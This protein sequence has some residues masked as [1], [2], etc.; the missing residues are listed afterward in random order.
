MTL[1]SPRDAKLFFGQE[2]VDGEL[3]PISGGVAAVFSARSP[4]KETPNEDAAA[5]IPYDSR[6][7][8][9]VVADGLGGG[10]AGEEAASRAIQA[11]KSSIQDASRHGSLLR[12]AIIN[13]CERANQEIREMGL[14][15]ATTLAV[16]EIQD[17]VVRPYHVGDSMILV[18]GQ[19]GKV[20]L[21]TISHSPVGYAVEAGILDESEAMHHEDR[22]IVSNVIGTDEMRI[23]LGPPLELAPR[24]TLLL[25]SDGLFDNLL[26]NEIVERLRK[27]PLP[28]VVA[29]LAADSRQRMV[30]PREGEPNKP[31]DL[32][33]VA[34]RLTPE[35]HHPPA[36]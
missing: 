34:F 9:L 20:K 27:G 6:S 5:L 7:A 19:R 24:D 17:A 15:A 14:G 35:R 31:D 3:H 22:H 11:L 30:E 16:A 10:L 32:T 23:E 29:R 8:A 28:R 25:A 13:G 4:G 36:P 12:S 1:E 2:M 33:F 18:V 26:T 21:Q